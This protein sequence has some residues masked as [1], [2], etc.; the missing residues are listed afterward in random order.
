MRIAPCALVR[1]WDS[2]DLGCKVAAITHGHHSGRLAAG[3][4]A[5]I[6][7]HVLEGRDV[8]KA[9]S[10]ALVR[11]IPEPG[12]E[13]CIAALRRAVDLW[14]SR[15]AA[16]DIEKLGLGWV[17][18]E[19]LSMGVYAALAGEKN[20]HQGLTIAVNH[21]G[22]SDSTGAI[23]GNILGALH[24]ENAVI[25]LLD[26]DDVELRDEIV[27]LADDLLDAWLESSTTV[28]HGYGNGI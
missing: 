18:D 14:K 3:A 10:A 26:G 23:A 28:L 24:G 21:S 22:D 13:E 5:V 9:I 27:R 15:A 17:A 7:R 25:A 12:S 6:I 4:L 1:D 16:G 8:A 11:L 20:L 2:F 19:A